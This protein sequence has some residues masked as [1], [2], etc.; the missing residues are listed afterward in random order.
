MR[1]ILA[2]A[3]LAAV[4]HVP[5]GYRVS[6]YASGLQHP[7]AMS[8]GPNGRLYVSEDVGKIVSVARGE[9]QPRPFAGGL[10]VPLGLLWR[11]RTLY[12]SE[13]GK[14][15]AL[16]AGR[17]RRVV[18]SGLPYGEHQQDA[19]VAGPDGRLYLGSGSTC[20][21]CVEEDPRS[22]AILSFK[23]DG[24][25]LRVVASGLRNPYGLVFVG[26]TLYA[27]VNGKD[28]LGDTEPA[29]T[30]VRVQRGARYGW[31]DCW[32]SYALKKLTGSCAGVTRPVAY[33]EPH[34]SADGIA[35]WRGDLYVAEWG[36]YLHHDHGRY[37]VR[38]A[39]GRPTT[40][41]TGFDHPL[42]VAVDPSGDL[43]VA[44]WGQG[45]IYAIR[46]R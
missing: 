42:A 31:P 11:G 26:K 35:S 28:K 14:V 22:A 5:H 21:A 1:A 45:V 27:T 40:F 2:A 12:V 33:L 7:T 20:D 4:I 41:A 32:A 8:F 23:P 43:L 24:S 13:S 16:R 30:V 10:T 3:A 6:T 29:E 38:I 19:I 37:L 36:E 39:N 34:S 15:E 18:L 46:K 25:D 9:T 44:D 17:P